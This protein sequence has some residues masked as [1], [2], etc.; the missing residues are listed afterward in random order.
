[1]GRRS[2][3]SFNVRKTDL[4]FRSIYHQKDVSTMAHL[5]LGFWSIDKFDANIREKKLA[6]L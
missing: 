4:D 1:M 3:S 2:K 6:V 5:Y